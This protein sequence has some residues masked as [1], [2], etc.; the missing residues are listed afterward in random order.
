MAQSCLLGHNAIGVWLA[1][2]SGYSLMP[3]TVR[4]FSRQIMLMAQNIIIFWP[5]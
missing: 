3:V 4:D 1:P 5:L 2:E